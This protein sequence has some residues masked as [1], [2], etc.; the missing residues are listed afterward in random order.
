MN[1]EPVLTA[2]TVSGAVIALASVFGIVLETGLVETLIA[3]LLPIILALVA[4]ARVSPV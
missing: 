1:T 3:A 2:A 4:R